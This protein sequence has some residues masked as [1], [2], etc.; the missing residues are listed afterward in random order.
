MVRFQADALMKAQTALEKIWTLA[1]PYYEKARP[2]DLQHVK[3]MA[4]IAW[5]VCEAEELDPMILQ[6]AAALH[7]IGYSGI[8]SHD[9]RSPTVKI[10]HMQRGVRIAGRILQKTNFPG[11]KMLEVLAIIGEHDDWALGI[12]DVYR[13]DKMVAVLGDL[14]FL[15]LATN[16][17]FEIVRKDMGKTHQEMITFLKTN[18]KHTKRPWATKTTQ[19][20]FEQYLQEREKDIAIVG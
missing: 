6:T 8:D 19:A 12:D 10:R 9:Y 7:D 17:G 20:L 4:D 2:F 1:T 18:E 15:Y 3:W 13:E 14:D 5:K 11:E 16:E